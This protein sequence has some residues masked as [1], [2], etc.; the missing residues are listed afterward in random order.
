MLLL[1]L[2]KHFVFAVAFVLHV[3]NQHTSEKAA[4]GKE[5]MDAAGEASA[6]QGVRICCST[7]EQRT[8]QGAAVPCFPF[9][10]QWHFAVGLFYHR[11]LSLLYCCSLFNSC[12]YVLP[13]I[14]LLVENRLTNKINSTNGRQELVYSSLI[15]YLSGLVKDSYKWLYFSLSILYSAV[16]HCSQRWQS[17]TLHLT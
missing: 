3:E 17:R 1:F 10:L 8:S 15:N 6:S 14:G 11:K 16:E 2:L 5:G 4:S 7:R 13:Q 9:F 12:K